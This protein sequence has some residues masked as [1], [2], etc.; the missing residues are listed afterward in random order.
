MKW[1]PNK[2]MHLEIAVIRA[3]QTLNQATLGEVL[4]TLTAIRG[5]AALP[6]PATKAPSSRPASAPSRTPAPVRAAAPVV[7][8]P[9]AK[10]ESAA[11]A[12]AASAE[13]AEPEPSPKP[14]PAA[15][16]STPAKR[17]AQGPAPNIAEE[18]VAV[19]ADLWPGVVQRVRKERPLQAAN[20][21]RAVLLEI[22]GGTAFVGVDTKDV[23][24]FDMLDAASMRKFL[25]GILSE[26]AATPLAIKLV[27]REGI[28]P[29]PVPR[30]AEPEPEQPKDPMAEFKNDALIRK[31]LELFRAEIQSA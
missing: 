23:L 8:K 25:E 31:A 9:A 15:K 1:A 29:A 14:A 12:P 4:D 3:I 21:E 6:E 5:G 13:T 20:V 26:I 19:S 24:A 7:A 27:K 2:K 22:K 11:E 30:A 17:A 18:P 10:A 28:A 16:S